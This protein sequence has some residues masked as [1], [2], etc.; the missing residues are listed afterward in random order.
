[1]PRR[2]L[3]VLADDLTG[4]AEVAAIAHQAGLRAVVFTQ[5]PRGPVDADVLVIDTDTRLASPAR[6]ARQVRACVSRL[7]KLPQAGFFKKTDSVLR[8]PVLAELA[9]CAQ[10]L[11]FRRVLLVPANP[12]L[13]R[14]IRDGRC[15]IA[16]RPLHETAFA[17]DPHHPAR[18]SAVLERLGVHKSLPAFSRSPGARLP[19][20]GVIVGDARTAADIA[21]W[22]AAVNRHTL[23]AGGADFFRAWLHLQTGTPRTAPGFA[24]PAGGALLL[25][26]TTSAP[27]DGR[28]LVFRG[29]RAPATARVAGALR[30]RGSVAVAA[31][32]RASRDPRAPAAISR[33]FATLARRLHAAS[34]FRHLL[35]AGGATA[36]AVLRDLGWSR[37]EVVRVWGPGVVTLQ[38]FAASGFAVTLKP[39]S[40]PWPPGIRRS[41]PA[42][43]AP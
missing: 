12:S 30:D 23:P 34:A 22:A 27:V 9:A 35:I 21:D 26:G 4:A 37:L 10:V 29:T 24:L 1:M 43:F 39:G 32:T 18:S 14:V 42:V 3:L 20:D 17:R 38:P 40:Y 15:F 28:A 19:H 33:G 7:K 13:R 31:A 8:G 5:P 25:H 16:G 36:A 41:V 2:P 6:A 11:G